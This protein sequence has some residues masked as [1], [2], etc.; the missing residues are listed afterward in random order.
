MRRPLN[1]LSS[2]RNGSR[3]T[4][5]REGDFRPLCLLVLSSCLPDEKLLQV[6]HVSVVASHSFFF[7]FLFVFR[8]ASVR[9]CLFPFGSLQHRKTHLPTQCFKN[10]FKTILFLFFKVHLIFYLQSCFRF[11][12]L[13]PFSAYINIERARKR[14]LDAAFIRKESSN[15]NVRSNKK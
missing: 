8:V 3:I 4:A 14:P 6:V 10:F 9:H 12:Y 15:K 1:P 5:Y 11:L 7:F 13:K 2:I